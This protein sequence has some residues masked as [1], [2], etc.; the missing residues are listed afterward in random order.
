MENFR[1][2]NNLVDWFVKEKCFRKVLIIYNKYNDL[3][4]YL[5]RI[6]CEEQVEEQKLNFFNCF[7]IT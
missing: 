6:R 4:I 2:A 3:E 5:W 7:E 1:S